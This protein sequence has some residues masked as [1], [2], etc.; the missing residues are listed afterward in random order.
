MSA[1][2]RAHGAGEGTRLQIRDTERGI[3]VPPVEL[4]GIDAQVESGVGEA[5]TRP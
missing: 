2:G 3:F 4:I 1:S 5:S